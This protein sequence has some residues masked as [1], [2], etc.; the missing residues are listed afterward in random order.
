MRTA[1]LIS[2]GK[3]SCYNM[4]SCIAEGHDIVALI[5]LKPDGKDDLDSYMYQTVG[6]DA[7]HLF[8]AAM[9]LPL[10]R[11]TISGVPV[12]TNLSYSVNA[13]DEV[14]DLYKILEK[15]KT[16]K[17][18]NSV[19]VGAILSN[20]Q[21]IRVENVCHRLDLIVLAYLWERDQTTLLKEMV[22]CEVEAIVIKVATMGL[23]PN[24]HLGL[25]LRQL[26]S[27]MV[28][29]NK[30]GLNVCGEGG[31][32]ETL[33]LDC[34]ILKK[35]LVVD[36]AE[37]V[38]TS[39]NAIDHVGYLRF[40]KVH[41]EKKNMN[42]LC[43]KQLSDLPL[44]TAKKEIN[45]LRLKILDLDIPNPDTTSLCHF[46][47]QPCAYYKVKNFDCDNDFF[48]FNSLIFSQGG[49]MYLTISE[50]LLFLQENICDAAAMIISSVC[51][52]AQNISVF[53]VLDK[54][55][56]KFFPNSQP[57]RVFVGA[58]LPRNILMVLECK[59]LKN[60]NSDF[61]SLHIGSISHWV[62]SESFHYSQAFRIG[63]TVFVAGQVPFVPGSM[64][65]IDGSIADQCWLSLR[66]VS[67][68]LHSAYRGCNLCN[69]I[70]CVCYVDH[71]AVIPV[72]RIVW[73]K[74]ICELQGDG[75]AWS[76]HQQS[77]CL[78]DYVVVPFLPFAAHVEW[79]ST[80]TIDGTAF[81]MEEQSQE[82]VNFKPCTEIRQHG[83]NQQGL[84][85]STLQR[86]SQESANFMLYAKY[87]LSGRN[88]QCLSTYAYLRHDK[89]CSSSIIS[90]CL[91]FFLKILGN[92]PL[93]RTRLQ[94]FFSSKYFTYGDVYDGITETLQEDQLC[95]A[96]F[97]VVP[98]LQLGSPDQV[99][100][101]LY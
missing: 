15:V 90:V 22:D 24:I 35:K 5:N 43:K 53:H 37:T 78:L 100:M 66:H 96:R 23:R 62:P 77:T 91:R 36:N 31:E 29:H 79:Q 13:S 25:T 55:Q 82:F 67:R 32:Y 45:V 3:D 41:L 73:D 49:E 58:C 12:E 80:A 2:G 1:A 11:Q 65:I 70:R 81:T 88:L 93:N 64:E 9:D 34:P 97:S 46:S 21:R 57:I 89:E 51:V 42:L 56:R 83:R 30:F 48:Y 59:G 40:H 50:A 60:S 6:H 39:C 47:N 10:Y 18:I 8:G 54:A 68:I 75:G 14:E 63:G 101:L 38:I 98:V 84:S 19:S 28:E 94:I 61:S 26:L 7:V 76:S 20:Y 44:M 17:Y 52:F 16:E 69:V 33:T 74:Y 99:L 95:N 86:Y 92:L 87:L 72:A 4:M 71:P 27:V 85:I